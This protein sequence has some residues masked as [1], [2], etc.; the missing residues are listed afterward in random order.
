MDK[1]AVVPPIPGNITCDVLL[2]NGGESGCLSDSCFMSRC[3]PLMSP[4]G[5]KEMKGMIKCSFIVSFHLVRCLSKGI[6]NECVFC[7]I[8]LL[9]LVSKSTSILLIE[10]ICLFIK[11]FRENLFFQKF[12]HL[13]KLKIKNV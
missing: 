2:F 13:L 4:G 6:V 9:V 11:S 10:K 7:E 3:W 12:I 1:P 5:E 8:S